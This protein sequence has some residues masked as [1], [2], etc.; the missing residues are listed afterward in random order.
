MYDISK[1][2]DY[3]RKSYSLNILSYNEINYLYDMID[4]KTFLP[5]YSMLDW[6]QENYPNDGF[7]DS[8]KL[9]PND[10]ANQKFTTEVIIPFL[11]KTYNM[12][13][14]QTQN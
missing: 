5:I 2:T 1:L 3:K 13:S 11:K 7:D 14:N 9:K 6:V 12:E 4:K 10:F 8:E